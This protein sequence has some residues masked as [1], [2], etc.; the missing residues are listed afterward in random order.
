MTEIGKKQTLAVRLIVLSRLI[1][2]QSSR[3][4]NN[5]FNLSMA[6]WLVLGHLDTLRPLRLHELAD[7]TH[8]DKA[9][10]SRASGTLIQRG[11]VRKEFD[12]KDGRS[13]FFWLTEKG[14][15]IKDLANK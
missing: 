13:V 4:L 3:F 5:K 15:E 9:Q 12:L 10:L 7:I 8:A 14:H 11:L 1:S 6:E 2:R